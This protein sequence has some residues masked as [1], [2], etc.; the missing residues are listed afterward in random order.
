VHP[1]YRRCGHSRV[2]LKLVISE[3]RKNGHEG[4]IHIKADPREG[5]IGLA[6]LTRYYQS[7]G[8]T[9]DEDRPSE[10]RKNDG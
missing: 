7:M 4:D 3:I 2:L 6:D 1:Q 5:G 8:L 10:G 9:V